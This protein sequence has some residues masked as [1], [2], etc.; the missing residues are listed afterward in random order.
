VITTRRLRLGA[1]LTVLSAVAALSVG[2]G[3]S[4]GAAPTA[5]GSSLNAAQISPAFAMPA[6]TFTDTSGKPLNLL[7]EAKGLTTL[8]Y[9]GYTHCPDVCPTT[10]ADLGSA[11][12]SLPTSMTDHIQVVFITSDPARDT[13]AVMAHWLANFDTGLPRPFVGLT[14]PLPAIDAYAAKLGIPLEPPTKESDGTIEVTHG[15]E[16][17]VFGART[18][19]A[20]Y[21]WLP[22]TTP[23]QYAADLKKLAPATTA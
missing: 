5:A 19:Q 22:G 14:A 11:L 10:M 9:F 20:G 15:A 12:R 16:T 18:E 23:A 13:P 6:G 3:A 8:V 1:S 17:L 7:T 4:H 2:C 21:V